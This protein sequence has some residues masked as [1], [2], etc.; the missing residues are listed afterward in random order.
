MLLQSKLHELNA[1]RKEVK[2]QFADK[3]AKLV[4]LGLTDQV[5]EWDGLL[6]QV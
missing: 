6:K 4:S 1:V 3:R 5:R 2:N